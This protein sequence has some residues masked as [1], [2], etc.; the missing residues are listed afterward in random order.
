MPARYTETHHP[1]G[2]Q[3]LLDQA[4]EPDGSLS[5]VEACPHIYIHALKLSGNLSA[6]KGPSNFT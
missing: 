4:L 2:V 1:A 3:I 5:F 6:L